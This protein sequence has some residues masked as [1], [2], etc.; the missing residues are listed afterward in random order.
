MSK[1]TKSVRV[2]HPP[3]S[4]VPTTTPMPFSEVPAT[5][6][7]SEAVRPRTTPASRQITHGGS[8]RIVNQSKGL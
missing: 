4:S 7:Y 2:I 3:A 5:V 6:A 8:V 1:S